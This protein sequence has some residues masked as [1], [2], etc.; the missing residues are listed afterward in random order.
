[1]ASVRWHLSFGTCSH[2]MNLARSVAIARMLRMPL[3]GSRPNFVSADSD[4]TR[5]L[6]VALRHCGRYLSRLQ[7][8]SLGQGQGPV[9]EKVPFAISSTSPLA[10]RL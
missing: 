2:A 1:M 3:R 8:I 10:P 7:S 4:M 6:T 5:K 9:A